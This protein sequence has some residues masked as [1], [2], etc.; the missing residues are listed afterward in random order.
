MKV[1]EEIH[2]PIDRWRNSFVTDWEE[3]WLFISL[4]YFSPA[5]MRLVFACE[6]NADS[7]VFRNIKYRQQQEVLQ[8]L[9]ED[10]K[11]LRSTNNDDVNE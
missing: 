7:F 6:Q 9:I 10:E 3:N 2:P 8:G 11:Y 5:C 4:A 1:V